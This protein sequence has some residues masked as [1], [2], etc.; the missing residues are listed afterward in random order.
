MAKCAICGKTTFALWNG[1]VKLSD[2][3][4][5][6]AC[7][8]ALGF[9]PDDYNMLQYYPLEAV[10]QGK[11]GIEQYKAKLS[12]QYT[13]KE[14]TTSD[15]DELDAKVKKYGRLKKVNPTYEE[16]Q[17]FRAILDMTDANDLRLDRELNDIVVTLKDAL[18]IKYKSTDNAKWIRF[19][20]IDKQK[21]DLTE[22]DD[23]YE[24]EDLINDAIQQ[25]RY[26]VKYRDEY[27]E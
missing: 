22:P 24:Y 20:F 6:G 16:V 18:I 8:K 10:S 4:I 11:A 3:T 9:K 14:V 1:A 5:C 17:I 25:G 13:L 15:D 26:Y 19:P 2:A 27:D 23:V 21:Y 7:F 12:E